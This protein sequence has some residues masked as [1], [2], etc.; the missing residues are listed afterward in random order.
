MSKSRPSIAFSELEKDLWPTSGGIPEKWLKYANITNLKIIKV[1]FRKENIDSEIFFVAKECPKRPVDF[2]KLAKALQSNT[3]FKEQP[4]FV[5]PLSLKELLTLC[6]TKAGIK[7]L[8]KAS[9]TSTQQITSLSNSRNAWE[10]MVNL[11]LRKN[12][13]MGKSQYY[14]ILDVIHEDHVYEQ[15]LSTSISTISETSENP[16]ESSDSESDSPHSD[17]DMQDSPRDASPVTPPS[18]STPSKLKKSPSFWIHRESDGAQ[19]NV[20]IEF[21]KQSRS[22]S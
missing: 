22:P 20:F 15:K 10:I 14:P 5:S 17:S 12:K 9:K 18:P 1:S 4:W 13:A 6:Y 7:P 2:F 8:P 16:S 3:L 21:R 11:A 19:T